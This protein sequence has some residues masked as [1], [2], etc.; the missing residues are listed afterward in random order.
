MNRMLALLRASNNKKITL[1]PD[2]NWFLAFWPKFYGVTYITKFD[3]PFDD[4][5]HIDSSIMGLE[6]IQSDKFYAAPVIRLHQFELK[7]IH[8][9][10]LNI[11]V[12]LRK[13]IKFW[14][15]SMVKIFCDNMA[16]LQ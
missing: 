14:S 11:S 15:H 16:V 5:V 4:K 7:I 6:G 10:T 3:I 12:P 1:T 8:L 13:W 9:K 2:L